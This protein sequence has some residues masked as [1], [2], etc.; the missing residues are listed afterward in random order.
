LIAFYGVNIKST[1]F[2]LAPFCWLSIY[3]TGF[4]YLAV[5]KSVLAEKWQQ[6]PSCLDYKLVR[7][8]HKKVHGKNKTRNKLKGKQQLN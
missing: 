4:G 7:A 6:P 8:G 2:I 1:F 5:E 3:R